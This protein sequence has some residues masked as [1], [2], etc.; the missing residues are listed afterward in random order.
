MKRL[1]DNANTY[2]SESFKVPNISFSNGTTSINVEYTKKNDN[3]YNKY[4][5]TIEEITKNISKDYSY[6]IKLTYSPSAFVEGI[7][8][9]KK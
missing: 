4:L 5:D 2:K 9:N 1:K 6:D 7:E 3:N 8:I